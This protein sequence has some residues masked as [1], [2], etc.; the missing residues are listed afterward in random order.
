MILFHS[1]TFTHLQIILLIE[2]LGVRV[3]LLPGFVHDF[4][5]S[6]KNRLSTWN[7]HLNI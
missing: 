5:I 6:D 1:A 4:N 7:K 2:R 3:S